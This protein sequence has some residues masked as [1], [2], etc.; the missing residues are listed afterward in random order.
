MSR[1][2]IIIFGLGN[3]YR[4]MKRYFYLK[5]TEI[6]AL[7]DNDPELIGTV[8]DGYVVE[9]CGHIS[10]YLYDYIIISSDNYASEI[11]KQL[12]ETGIESE[13]L[14]HY[15]DYIGSFP[16]KKII[17]RTDSST[18]NVLILSN[19]FGY[20]GG[21]IVCL[22]LARTLIQKGYNVTI[23]VPNA[24][25]DFMTEIS[26]Q[27]LSVVVV[28][29][30]EGLSMEN[31]RWTEA[32]DYIVANTIVMA[33]CAIKLAG[34]RK[35]YLWLHE[36]VDSYACLEYW[37]EEIAE[38]IKKDLLVIGAVSEVA[39]KNFLNL[40]KTEKTVEV[41]PYGF[42]DRYNKK[43]FCNTNRVMTFVVIA[44]HTPLKGLD[45]LLKALNML[46]EDAK[47]Q[48][49]VLIAGKSYASKY[50]DRIRDEIAQNDI[51]TYLGE[52]VRK[53]IFELYEKSDVV[54]IPSRRDALPLVAAEAMMMKKTCILSDSVGTVCYVKHQCNGLIF[55][56]EDAGA[57]SEMITWC[58]EHR[59]SLK[60]I[61]ENARKTYEEIF[62]MKKFGDRVMAVIESL[63]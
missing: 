18:N 50:S 7:V 58:V 21:A 33:R 43:K 52:L 44:N 14:V 1:L 38:G 10:R 25:E 61:A 51:C 27:E 30:L 17:G 48:I 40:Y 24:E 56:N 8:V 2:K 32:Y 12:M 29:N 9:P 4:T 19:G 26:V 60:N 6:V 47:R 46:S 31:L 16:M 54:I 22:S 39:K 34:K 11:K 3:R 20:H 42:E 45:V 13:K 63:K 62:S 37:K 55:K 23:V 28:K 36:S 59:E 15:K 53:E 35:V 49:K 57:L 5:D 41:M